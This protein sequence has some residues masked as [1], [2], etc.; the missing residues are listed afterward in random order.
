LKIFLFNFV[1]WGLELL[2]YWF[3]AKTFGL[4]LNLRACA[5]IMAMTNLAMIAPSAPGGIGLF[6]FGGLVVFAL[7]G[8][9]KTDAVMYLLV[10]HFIILMPIN[11][12][13]FYY[14]IREKISFKVALQNERKS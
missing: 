4:D 14:M 12:W 2:T 6:E 13:G 1:P 8:M 9:N 7:L 10:V 11:V 5:L 3:V